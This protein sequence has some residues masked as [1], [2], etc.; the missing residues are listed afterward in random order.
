MQLDIYQVDAFA[1]KLFEGNP[2]AVCPLDFWPGDD[3][4]QRIALENNLS[5][6]AFFLKQDDEY[7]LRWFTPIVEVRLCG[8]ATL[9][10]AHVLFNEL[11]IDA[12]TIYFNTLSGKLSVSKIELGKYLMDFPADHPTPVIDESIHTS[13]HNALN[14]DIKEYWKGMDDFLVVLEDEEEVKS[15]DPDFR[16]ISKLPSR[17]L[18]VTA[19]SSEVDFISRGFF[20]QTGVDEDPATGSAH[21]LLTPYW[22]P[23]LRTNRIKAIQWSQRKG[24]FECIYKGNR[25]GLIGHAITYLKGSIFTK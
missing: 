17:G 9:A 4:L 24:Y 25:T 8:H 19:R 11:N 15:L 14:T 2:A 13:I 6:T 7:H 3:L 21:T 5:E 1:D 10:T 12:S 23:R 16:M 20:P 22:A 18:I